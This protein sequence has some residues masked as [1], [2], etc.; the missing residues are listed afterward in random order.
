VVGI[1]TLVG[2]CPT[3]LPPGSGVPLYKVI[4]IHSLH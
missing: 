3:L 1:R 2:D 4:E